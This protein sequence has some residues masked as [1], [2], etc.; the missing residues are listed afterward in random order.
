MSSNTG[1]N[2][3]NLTMNKETY[4]NPLMT[5]GPIITEEDEFDALDDLHLDLLRG[6]DPA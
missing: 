6:S 4:N 1:A 3:I 5:D 2:C